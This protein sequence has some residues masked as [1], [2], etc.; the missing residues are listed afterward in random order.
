MGIQMALAG[1]PNAGKTTLF[2]DL[3]G[4]NQF[5]GNWPGV[6]VE[7]K[8]GRL[9]GEDDVRVLDLPGIYSL[10]PYT[11][12]EVITREALFEEQPDVIINIVDATNIERNLYL[13]LQLLELDMPMVVALNMMDEVEKEGHHIRLNQLTLE[14][15][16]PVFPISALRGTGV[17]DLVKGALLQAQ[18]RQKP[19]GK[20]SYPN[21][22]EKAIQ[23]V[24][25]TLTSEQERPRWS[26][27]KLLEADP[28]VLESV[29]LSDVEQKALHDIRAALERQTDDDAEELIATARYEA[30]EQIVARSVHR[31]EETHTLS[32]RID[33]V[34]TH[35]V[36]AL[37]L[38]VVIM[39]GI[40]W[41]AMVGVGRNATDWANERLFGDGFTVFGAWVPGVPVLVENALTALHAP[42]WLLRLAVDG[43]VAG[44]GAVLGFLPQMFVLFFMLA[45]LE[46]CGYM[47][48]IAF[49]LDR[50]FR[51][52]GL[53]GKSFIPMLIGTGCSVPGIMATRTIESDRDRH[54]T[55][56][57]T[58]FLPCSAKVGVI[59]MISGALFGGSPAVATSSYFIGM[60]AVAL[61]GL[62]L[63]KTKRF[64]GDPSPFVMEMPPYRLPLLRNVLRTTW[65]HVKAFVRK[66]AS[67]ILLSTVIIWFAS[68]FGWVDGTFTML[69]E[70]EISHSLL[71]GIGSAIAWI[72][73]PLGWRNWQAAVASLSGL[74]AKE[75]IVSTLAVLN[76]VSEEGLGEAI[77]AMMTP[78]SGFSF[79][80]FN[81]LCAP[82]FAAIGAMIGEFR[83]AHWT[84][85]AV[86]YQCGFAYAISL[87]IYQFGS[88][89]MGE[90]HP[91]GLAAALLTL[92]VMIYFIAFKKT[93]PTHWESNVTPP[94]M[95]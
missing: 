39:F 33:A 19:V 76:Q 7:K 72:F 85:F 42:L 63:K 46:S 64:A 89:F 95:A 91:L 5:V 27:I 3:T 14:L 23:K 45:L 41:L 70:D 26:A 47:S 6:T 30:I 67:I 10:S 68:S 81:L 94:R 43:I 32:D 82:C 34:L 8:E 9:K 74:V 65:E 87:M 4:S 51:Y 66:A 55:I 71:A 83:S 61:S 56:M 16:C 69:A 25:Q 84:L 37:P 60:A 18:N 86:G 12:E 13:T 75:N 40:Y 20:R 38:F 1:N 59:S 36:L 50:L 49:V 78:L 31:K 15:G 35:R 54:V 62:M 80:V 52:F 17:D 58:S 29:T 77:A 28:R 21:A 88:L 2:N 79:L 22:L 57:T 90:V 11:L 92:G 44:V 48:R 73:A 24:E 53:S 93:P